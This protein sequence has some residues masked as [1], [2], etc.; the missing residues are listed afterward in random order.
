MGLSKRVTRILKKEVDPAF[1]ARAELIFSH[2][3]KTKPQKVVDIGCG[4]GFYLQ[5]LAGYRFIKSLV[6]IETKDEYIAKAKGYLKN[7]KIKLKKGDVYSLPFKSNSVDCVILS[8]VLEHLPDEDSALREIRRV[9]KKGGNL[10]ITVP[11]YNFPCAWDPANYFLMKCFNTHIR[12]DWWFVAGIWADHERLYT[13]KQLRNV[14]S[15]NKFNIDQFVHTIF[16][17]WPFTHFILYGIGKNIVEKLPGMSVNRFQVQK[18]SKFG[19]LLASFMNF[20]EK[21]TNSINLK[22]TNGVGLVAIVKK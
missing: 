9:L 6:G 14:I 1:A 7:K 18:E 4:R 10:I 8:E 2:I 12:S 15:K 16:H 21:I 5:T 11:H 20:P 22:K 17:V 19:N 3:E 13:E